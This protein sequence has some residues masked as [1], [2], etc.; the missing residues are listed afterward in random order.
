MKEETYNKFTFYDGNNW[1]VFKLVMEAY[2]YAH[3]WNRILDGTITIEDYGEKSRFPKQYRTSLT[4]LVKT[5]YIDSSD[6]INTSAS[7]GNNTNKKLEKPIDPD[8]KIDGLTKDQFLEGNRTLY[9][10]LISNLNPSQKLQFVGL[11]CNIL[12]L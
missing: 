5:E 3:N 12:C 2:A 11:Q 8:H 4:G 10:K 1:T 6:Q 9:Y 7:L